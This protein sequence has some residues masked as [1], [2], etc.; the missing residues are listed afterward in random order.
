MKKIDIAII[1][2]LLSVFT[3]CYKDLSTEADKVIPKIEI[4][5][6][7]TVLNVSYNDVLRVDPKVSQEN[8]SSEDFSYFWEMS[9][10]TSATTVIELGDSP[11]LEYQV[12]NLPADS[13]Y[14]LFLTVTDK[15]TGLGTMKQWKV[16]V[17]S[18]LGEGLVV[19]HTRDGGKTSDLDFVHRMSS[20][21]F[22]TNLSSGTKLLSTTG[23]FSG[24]PNKRFIC[25]LT[26]DENI[27][28][29]IVF[30][31]RLRYDNCLP[32]RFMRS[33]VCPASKLT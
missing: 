24:I 14:Y 5:N 13:P 10:N 8:R 11:I 12:T 7:D 21:S 1:I 26:L 16:Y 18:L 33:D 4:G 23:T 30:I 9:L 6:K 2:V 19:A 32:S 29:I 31:L 28:C 27:F 22:L 3:S 20:T 17:S 25:I 15:Q